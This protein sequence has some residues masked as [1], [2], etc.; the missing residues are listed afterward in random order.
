MTNGAA[1]VF[2]NTKELKFS[3]HDYLQDDVVHTL[4]KDLQEK[5]NKMRIFDS[6]NYIPTTN[7]QEHLQEKLSNH[8]AADPS[9]KIP[10]DG[11]LQN[12]GILDEKNIVDSHNFLPAAEQ[13]NTLNQ[14]TFVNSQKIVP[15]VEKSSSTSSV[16]ANVLKKTP[17]QPISVS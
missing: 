6:L 2:V 9:E 17:R 7:Q 4:Q 1:N 11:Q 10:V 8:L 15:A 12:Q 14:I 5:M 16:S 13:L 3:L